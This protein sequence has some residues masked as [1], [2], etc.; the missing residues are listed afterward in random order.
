M[1]KNLSDRF[2]LIEL[3]VVIA[4]IAILAALLLPSLRR[5]KDQA[6]TMS[7]LTNTRQLYV[8]LLNYSA[9][10]DNWLPSPLFNGWTF[11]EDCNWRSVLFFND[12]CRNKQSFICSGEEA[13]WIIGNSPY[14]AS[15]GINAW[16]KYR[17][18]QGWQIGSTRLINFSHPTRT[19]LLGDNEVGDWP[20]QQ[21]GNVGSGMAF[22]HQNKANLAFVD[23]HSE[24]IG[25]SQVF[26]AT[27][28][29][30]QYWQDV[31]E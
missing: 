23:G 15:Y 10:S 12:Y 7:C 20:L 16:S 6:K 24:S 30:F 25:V 19:F 26:P 31:W 29:V 4:I 28:F 8:A 5:A 17:A 22:R 14:F 27:G 3:L 11:L 13:D 18:S 1:M 21:P 9:D 2:T